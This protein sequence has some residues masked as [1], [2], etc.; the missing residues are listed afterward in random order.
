M[1]ATTRKIDE[2]RIEEIIGRLREVWRSHPHL[3]L[4][5]IIGNV[6]PH[7]LPERDPYYIEDRKFIESIEYHYFKATVNNS[8]K[9][10]DYDKVD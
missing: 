10:I 5:Q 2:E 6:Y 8:Y 1:P 9:E 7:T 3:R 4:A